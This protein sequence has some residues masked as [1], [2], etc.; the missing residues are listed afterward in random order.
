MAEVDQKVVNWGLVLIGGGVVLGA[1][2]LF[3]NSWQRGKTAEAIREDMLLEAE[4]L[5]RYLDSITAN[6][7]EPTS[8][9]WDRYQDLLDELSVKEVRLVETSRTVWEAAFDDILELAS[10]WY[11]I[12]I[13]VAAIYL[14][15]PVAGYLG[16]KLFSNWFRFKCRRC[17]TPTCSKCGK[18]FATEEE[19]KGHIETSHTV[20]PTASIVEAQELFGTV[21]YWVQVGVAAES[22]LYQKTEQPWQQLS[23]TELAWLSFAMMAVLTIGA[24]PVGFIPA[25]RGASAL[26]L[27]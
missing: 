25:L 21:P 1:G 9:E 2:Y 5:N 15:P 12:P 16:R 27:V 19:L 24:L 8:G 10:M 11:L 6:G 7:R 20:A 3:Y 23:P 22:G 18:Q 14:G 4:A 26:L 13:A 17:T